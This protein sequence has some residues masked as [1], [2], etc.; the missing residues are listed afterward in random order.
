MS[1]PIY[2]PEQIPG[3]ITECE[4]F[5][6]YRPTT[7]VL[8]STGG[9]TPEF[10]LVQSINETDGVWWP[11]QGGLDGRTPEITAES[12]LKEEVGL[13][14]DAEWVE[15]LDGMDYPTG[16][17]DGYTDGKFLVGCFVEFNSL[18]ARL[19]PNPEELADLRT[20][21]TKEFRQVMEQNKILRPRTTSKADFLLHLLSLL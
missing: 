3:H 20:V 4:L 2:T 15:V 17:R 14:I 19:K 6:T 18:T 16:S 1:F 9:Y 7:T 11:V 21:N 13:T 8:A 10:V 5:M 12:E